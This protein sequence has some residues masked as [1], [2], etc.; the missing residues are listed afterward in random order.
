MRQKK[1]YQTASFIL[2]CRIQQSDNAYAECKMVLDKVL[3]APLKAKREGDDD[4]F[5]GF[6][7]NVSAGSEENENYDLSDPPSEDDG[8]A[9]ED[10]DEVSYT[11]ATLLAHFFARYRV[12]LT[13]SS[14]RGRR[15]RSANSIIIK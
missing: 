15:C 10:I 6:P 11:I 7:D 3:H 14:V 9:L 12:T 5:E 1:I 2:S 13:S 8:S 4:D